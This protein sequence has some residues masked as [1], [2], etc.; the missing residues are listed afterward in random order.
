[1]MLA[2]RLKKPVEEIIQLS[3]LEMN[4]WAGYLLYEHK[5]SQKTMNNNSIPQP[6]MPVRRGRKR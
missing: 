1:M 3:T 4:L 5:Q 2:D 6:K